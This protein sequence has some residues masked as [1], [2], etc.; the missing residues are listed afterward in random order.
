MKND[1]KGDIVFEIF[2]IT[3]ITVKYKIYIFSRNNLHF[4]NM[5]I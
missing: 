2:Y 4:I 5:K 1:I 3:P